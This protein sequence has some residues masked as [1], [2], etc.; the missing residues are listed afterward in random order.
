MRR[1]AAVVTISLAG[2]VAALLAFSGEGP[3]ACVVDAPEDPAYTAEITGPV[4]MRERTFTLEVRREGQPVADV[5]VCLSAE[6]AGQP[7]TRISAHADEVA[8]GRYELPVDFPRAGEWHGT[9]LIGRDATA[10]E[11]SVPVRFEVAR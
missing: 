4:Q 10:F 5:R 11:A 6:L 9:V 2:F 8:Q 3:R 7:G 1:L